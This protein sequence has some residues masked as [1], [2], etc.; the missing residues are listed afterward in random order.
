MQE[1]T[2]EKLYE[3]EKEYGALKE[4][5]QVLINEEQELMKKDEIVK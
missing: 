2:I 1:N 4:E 5:E 3:L